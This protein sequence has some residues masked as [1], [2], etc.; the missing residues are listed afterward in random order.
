MSLSHA[1]GIM[2]IDQGTTSSRAIVF[3]HDGSVLAAAQEPFIQ[4]FPQPGW[5]EHDPENIWATQ[6]RCCRAA[7]E[8][9]G[10]RAAE[11]AAIGIANQRETVLLWDAE[12]G[13]PLGNAIVWQCRRTAE[14]CAALEAAG[15]GGGVAALTGLR[16][17]PYFSAT[18]LEWLLKNVKGAKAKAAR[19]G[20]AA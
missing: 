1:N 12:T 5:V 15:Y 13:S 8:A 2:A 3:A 7:L 10:L 16:L 14:R 9:S 19:E 4:H 6:L 20:K 17:D 18:K 11:L